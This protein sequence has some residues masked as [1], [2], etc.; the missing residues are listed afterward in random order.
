MIT[1]LMLMAAEPPFDVKADPVGLAKQHCARQW[2]DDFRMQEHCLK[3]AA[4]GMVELKAV[5]D[6]FGTKL[7]KA[8]EECVELWTEDRLPDWRMIGYCAKQQA[9]AYE[10]LRR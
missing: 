8:L 2:P 4:Q 5:H 10:R 1:A 7:E 9:D 3:L 6:E